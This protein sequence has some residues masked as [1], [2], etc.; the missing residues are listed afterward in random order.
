[1]PELLE[2]PIAEIKDE[3]AHVADTGESSGSAVADERQAEP[4][5]EFHESTAESSYKLEAPVLSDTVSENTMVDESVAV[6]EEPVAAHEE[7]VA[8]LEEPVAI[9][10]EPAAILE[11][12]V[13]VLEEPA[14]VLEEPVA[15][16]AEPAAALEET[17]ALPDEPVAEQAA[18]E[19][20]SEAPGLTDEPIEIPA[21]EGEA[22]VLA[23]PIAEVAELCSVAADTEAHV[24]SDEVT[25]IH[26]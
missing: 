26:D 24:I 9:L 17:G 20:T 13:A 22:A 3:T 18:F 15:V 8:I 21:T 2:E 6:L 19:S 12:P 23:E 25:E 14:A 10:E 7:P 16:L 1:M 4:A 11:E 5:I